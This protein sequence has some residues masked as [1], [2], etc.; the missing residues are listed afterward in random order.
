VANV[1]PAPQPVDADT[2]TGLGTFPQVAGSDGRLP[3]QDGRIVVPGLGW[4]WF[5]EH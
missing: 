1:A 5:A 3:V 2:V 4:A